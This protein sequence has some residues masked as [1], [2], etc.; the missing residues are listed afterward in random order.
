M[1]FKQIKFY[2]QHWDFIWSFPLTLAVIWL[3][4]LFLQF[5]FGYETGTYDMAFLQPLFF[6]LAIVI[7][8]TNGAVFGL[9]LTLKGVYRYI[10]GVEK[11]DDTT[12]EKKYIN[13]SA[14]DWL[15]LSPTWR[16]VFWIFWL[17][18]FI[19]AIIFVYSLL[20]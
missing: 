5:A 11:K 12:G 2:L 6:S 20:V 3:F 13:Y 14:I 10:Y 4:G 16:F 15:K 17:A 9:M 19:T 7:G 1:K 18:Y 8:A